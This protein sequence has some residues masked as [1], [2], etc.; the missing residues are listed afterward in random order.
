MRLLSRFG[1]ARKGA[2]LVEFSLLAPVLILLMCG[3]SEFANAMR[4]YHVMEKGVRDAARYL[5]RV[6]MSACALDG[7]AVTA[8]KNLAL[9]GQAAG[10]GTYFLPGWSD[11]STVTVAVAACVSNTP[12]IY[13]GQ[14]QMP[15]IEVTARAPY[16][17]LGLLSVI[18][19]NGIALEVRHQQL[20]IGN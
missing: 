4:Q 12:R 13:R 16:Q 6:P 17:D 3:L 15:V 7:T 1:R 18:G 19:I 9:T 20:W 10:G 11:P 8:A 5:T 14:S 2:A